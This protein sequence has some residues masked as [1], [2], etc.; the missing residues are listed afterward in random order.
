MFEKDFVLQYFDRIIEKIKVE[1]IFERELKVDFLKNKAIAIIGPRRAGKTYFLLNILKNN[2]NALYVDLEH[3]AFKEI[4]HKEFFEIISIF[5]EYF[6]TKVEKVIIDEIQNLNNWE[7]LVRSLLDSGY[8]LMVSGSSSKLL[9]K[10]VSTQL[11][12]RS[13]SYVLLP[14]SFREYLKFKNI[15]RKKLISISEKV[16]IIKLLEEFLEWGSYP[17]ILVYPEKKEKIL[18]EYFDT[19]FQKDFIERFEIVHTY[20]AKLLFEFAIQNFSK[21]ISLN[22]IANFISSKIGRNIKNIVYDYAEK[23]PESLSIF[24][25]EK[26]SKSIYERKSLGRKIYV[27]DLGLVSMLSMEKN[28]G[29][30]MENAVF[31][32]LLRN[33]NFNPLQEI[34]Y[35]KDYQ[36]NEVDFLI[37]EGLEIKQL[38]QVTYASNKDEIEKREIKALLKASELLKCKDLLIITW[39]YEDEIK[40]NNKTIKCIPLW[41]WLL[42]NME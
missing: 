8:Y 19:I 26:L 11:R 10:E 25:V 16:K 23:L 3:S 31:L 27:C 24:F 13:L 28:I 12:G 40:I 34:Y 14:L 22:K 2:K 4:T 39:D 9:S 20:I 29:R 15:E 7:S 38:I 30:R 32:E 21:E 35:F 42:K 17:E 37:K 33:T 5:E 1:R 41:K 36:Q 18:K 6:K